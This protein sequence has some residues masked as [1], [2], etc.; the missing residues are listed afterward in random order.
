MNVTSSRDLFSIQ[1]RPHYFDSSIESGCVHG[2]RKA[3]TCLQR[4]RP[5]RPSFVT[6]RERQGQRFVAN[7]A[8]RNTDSN[9]AIGRSHFHL[10]SSTEESL[11][12]QA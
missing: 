4:S 2:A 9:S 12:R 10:L 1:Q 11:F 5:T 8:S 6:S 3:M 7:G